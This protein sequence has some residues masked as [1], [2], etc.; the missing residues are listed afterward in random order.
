VTV[1]TGESAKAS[2][3]AKLGWILTG[4]FVL[5]GIAEHVFFAQSNGEVIRDGG[6]VDPDSYMRVMR[7]VALYHAVS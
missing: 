2:G 6:L 1:A 5:L 3:G 7:I 4:L